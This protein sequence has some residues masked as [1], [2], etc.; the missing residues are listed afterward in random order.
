MMLST[1]R[2][3]LNLS[4]RTC[5][6]RALSI[7]IILLEYSTNLYLQEVLDSLEHIDDD[8]VNYEIFIKLVR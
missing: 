3:L 5:Q 2:S 1:T 7:L 4:D 6:Y 8:A